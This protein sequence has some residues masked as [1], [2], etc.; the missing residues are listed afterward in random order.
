VDHLLNDLRQE[1]RRPE[2]LKMA[3]EL[4]QTIY[5]DQPYTF[6]FVPE[7]TSV[8]WKGSYRIRQPGQKPGEWI[9]TPVMMSKAGW[10]YNMEW[11]Y[12]SEYP[13][14]TLATPPQP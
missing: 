7:S 9:D 10:S 13:P 2:I 5:N 4:Q 1:Y 14:K 3:G 6:L 8:M 12:R 11:F